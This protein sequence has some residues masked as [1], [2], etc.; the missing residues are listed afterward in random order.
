MILKHLLP[1]PGDG[2][3]TRY[4]FQSLARGLDAML[5]R[6]VLSDFVSSIWYGM[7]DAIPGMIL[8]II[9]VLVVFVI[10][11]IKIITS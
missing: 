5:N 7:V 3:I 4:V 9:I 2:L 6:I 8:T 11:A 1:K 10:L